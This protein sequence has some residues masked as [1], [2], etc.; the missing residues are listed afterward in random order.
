M[1]MIIDTS[2]HEAI[3]AHADPA[4]GLEVVVAIHN[5]ARGPAAGG[6]R[7]Q[8]YSDRQA[9]LADALRLSR[10]MSYKSALAGVRAGGGK[11]VILAPPSLVKTPAMF[12]AYGA[13]L[14]RIGDVFA[15]GE[16]VGFSLGDTEC[17]RAFSPFVAGTASQGQGDPGEHTARG[18]LHAMTA[19]AGH[20]W[21]A[22][23]LRGL[24]VVVQGLGGVGARL[25]RMLAE[26]GA[27]LSVADIDQ[28]RAA[29]LAADVGADVVPSEGVHAI[30]ADIWAP[31]ALGGVITDA[32]V[33]QVAARAIVGAANNQL[34]DP[35]LADRLAARGIIWI[36]D[37][38]VNA[39]GVIGAE[40]ELA[41][42]PGRPPP[43]TEPLEN[44]LKA[45][46]TRTRAV[47]RMA[48]RDGM[49]PFAAANALAEAAL[50]QGPAT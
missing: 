16:D 42:I 34:A 28:D 17:L 19:V 47:L 8:H 10:A 48:A 11:A 22:T 36:P 18:V 5:T 24:R 29:R 21:A 7:F 37:F 1:R 49:T 38:L 3:F 44:R 31:C 35:A 14:N 2:T 39:G 20:C 4:S 6:T 23:D 13:F 9:A 25:A 33:D 40:E 41:R 46:G 12:A 26:R 50:Q 15:T 32:M 45:I 43:P 27:M 30:D